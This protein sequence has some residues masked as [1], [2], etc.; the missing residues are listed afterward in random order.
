ME[1]IIFASEISKEDLVI[2]IG[3]GIG[4]LTRHLCEKGGKVIAIELDDTLFKPLEY[5]LSGYSNYEVI[6]NDVLEVDI[7]KL[8]DEKMEKDLKK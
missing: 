3:P 5:M 2:E 4:S 6:I 1:D 7:N 8:I